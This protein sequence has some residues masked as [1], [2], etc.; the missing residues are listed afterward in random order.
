M[1]DDLEI[2][3]HDGQTTL[4]MFDYD[5]KMS[6]DEFNQRCMPGS[7][8]QTAEFELKPIDLA[9]KN[10]VKYSIKTINNEVYFKELKC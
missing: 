2:K 10:G 5:I 6:L 9:V 8:G 1:S 7:A 4:D 3:I